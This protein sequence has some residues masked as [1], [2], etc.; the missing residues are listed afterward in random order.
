LR[1]V[2]DEQADAAAIALPACGCAETIRR[3]AQGA[4]TTTRLLPFSR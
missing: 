3:S 1:L 4:P 2:D